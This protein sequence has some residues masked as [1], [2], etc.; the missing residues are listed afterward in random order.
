[1]SRRQ[2]GYPGGFSEK[3]PKMVRRDAMG[4]E[5]ECEFLTAERRGS[6]FDHQPIGLG[7][8]SLGHRNALEEGWWHRNPGHGPQSPEGTGGPR[9]P[10]RLRYELGVNGCAV[11]HC[12]ELLRRSAAWL[13]TNRC[14]VQGHA[15][16]I[17]SRIATR[18]RGMPPERRRPVVANGPPAGRLENPSHFA[19][20]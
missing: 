3:I 10:R 13:A 7:S 14:W 15:R 20:G 9:D 5:I 12:E 8:S 1:M 18:F 19:V 17:A 6:R 4:R 16:E 2:G 11:R